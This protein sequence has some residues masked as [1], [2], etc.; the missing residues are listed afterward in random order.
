MVKSVSVVEQRAQL[1]SVRDRQDRVAG[2]LTLLADAKAFCRAAISSVADIK[3]I[4]VLDQ[5]AS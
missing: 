1:G 5:I 3:F 4:D 2:V